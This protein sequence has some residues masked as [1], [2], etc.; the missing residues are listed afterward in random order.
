MPTVFYFSVVRLL[1][2]ENMCSFMIWNKSMMNKHEGR[3]DNTVPKATIYILTTSE[4][5]ATQNGIN[6][7]S[8]YMIFLWIHL[9][10]KNIHSTASLLQQTVLLTSE[11]DF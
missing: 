1:Y 7:P 2:R 5:T 10:T 8:L 4:G 11:S 3:T 6:S 9:F